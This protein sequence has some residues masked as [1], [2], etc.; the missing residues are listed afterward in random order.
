MVRTERLALLIRYLLGSPNGQA[1]GYFLAQ[2][3]HRFGKSKTIEKVTVFRADSGNMPYLLFWV[4]DAPAGPSGGDV[5]VRELGND[6]NG[7]E[8]D[9]QEGANATET[10]AEDIKHLVKERV[11]RRVDERGNLREHVFRARL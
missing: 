9:G 6:R 4:I 3:K 7:V 10:K 11:V 5:E 2:H 8:M 1:A